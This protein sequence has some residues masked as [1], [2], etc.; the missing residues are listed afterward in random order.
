MLSGTAAG[1]KSV[2]LA[3][4]LAAGAEYICLMVTGARHAQVHKK[5]RRWLSREETEIY[6]HIRDPERGKATK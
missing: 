4:T 3:F 5:L 6:Q 1:Q 2:A